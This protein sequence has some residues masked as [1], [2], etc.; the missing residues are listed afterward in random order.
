MNSLRC[1]CFF[2]LL[3]STILQQPVVS[4]LSNGTPRGAESTERN[5]SLVGGL[6]VGRQARGD[7]CPK[8]EQ[9]T[10]QGPQG[11][12]PWQMELKT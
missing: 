9:P 10:G 1:F 11:R 3:A 6:S 12:W 7:L 5:Q 8:A 4:V 2:V